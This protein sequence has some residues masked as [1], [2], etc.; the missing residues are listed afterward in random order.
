[1]VRRYHDTQR[2]LVL[3]A[4]T[5]LLK[6]AEAIYSAVRLFIRLLVPPGLASC[7]HI[8]LNRYLIELNVAACGGII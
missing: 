6:V 2:Q 3:E 4:Q 8:R 5:I 1:M 7:G